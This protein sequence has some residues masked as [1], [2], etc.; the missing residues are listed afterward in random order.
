MSF[1]RL[2]SISAIAMVLSACAT[3]PKGPIALEKDALAPGKNV[4]VAMSALPTPD[5]YFPGADCLLCYAAASVMH[6]NLTAHTKTLKVDELAGVKAQVMDKLRKRGL[7]VV[8]IAQPIDL[9]ELPDFSGNENQ[10][11][12]DFSSLKA[13]YNIDKLVMLDLKLAGFS[14]GFAAYVPVAEPKAIVGGVGYLLDLQSNTY[15][16]YK[17]LSVMKAAQGSWDEPPQY[18]GLTNAYYQALEI[19]KDELSMPLAQ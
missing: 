16:W 14:R 15:Q 7:N 19:S 11:R 18:P 9:K 4:G 12:K 5:T 1:T 6:T 10:P 3:G 17:P 13:K 2:A 8:D